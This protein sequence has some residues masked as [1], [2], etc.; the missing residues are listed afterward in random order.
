MSFRSSFKHALV[1]VVVAAAPDAGSAATFATLHAFTGGADGSQPAGPLVFAGG[2]VYGA[3]A[4]SITMGHFTCTAPNCG[5]VYTIDPKSGAVTTLYQFKQDA[6][7]YF[8]ETGLVSDGKLLYGLTADGGTKGLGVVFRFDPATGA[9]STLAPVSI[10]D[11]IASTPF[12]YKGSLIGTATNGT[13]PANAGFGTVYK[14]DLKSGATTALYGF[15]GSPENSTGDAWYPDESA[16]LNPGMI[17]GTTIYGGKYGIGGTIWGV[18]PNTGKEQVLYSFHSP[19]AGLPD[20]AN[21]VGT[22]ALVGPVMYG[23]ASA[24]GTINANSVVGC[25]SVFAFNFATNKFT[26][27][28]DFDG[29]DGFSPDSVVEYKGQ[30]YVATALGGAYGYGAVVRIDEKTGKTSVIHAFANTGDGYYPGQLQ[31]H[32]G[33]IYGQTAYLFGAAPLGT[34]FTITP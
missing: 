31:L 26:V 1:W 22:F 28:H 15:K 23:A 19:Y 17:Y 34:I 30:L 24:G 9:V 20:G 16:E 8:P 14:I 10:I 13:T 33:V 3:T 12:V 4:G 29:T 7:G 27:V 18:T 2:K 25:G 32:D 11:Q 6:S 21:P 5:T